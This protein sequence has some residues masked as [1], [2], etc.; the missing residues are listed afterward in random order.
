M[1]TGAGARMP[2][3]YDPLHIPISLERFDDAIDSDIDECEVQLEDGRGYTVKERQKRRRKRSGRKRS[4]K[5]EDDENAAHQRKTLIVI[6]T[7]FVPFVLACMT[8]TI[9]LFSTAGSERAA[10]VTATNDRPSISQPSPAVPTS[11]S[12]EIFAN[13]GESTL[14][15]T[16]APSIAVAY[17][18]AADSIPACPPA[19]DKKTTTYLGGDKVT[20]TESIFECHSLYVQYCN[21]GD[22]DKALLARDAEADEKWSNAWVYVGPCSTLVALGPE[23]TSSPISAPSIKVSKEKAAKQKDGKNV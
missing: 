8:L 6:F 20:I 21:I 5:D 15:P 23:P 13:W 22:W 2:P 4:S 9:A 1:T 17:A 16:S 19:Y 10:P 18:Q 12:A 14:S 11:S 3:A 7:S